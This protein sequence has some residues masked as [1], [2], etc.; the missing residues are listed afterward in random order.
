MDFDLWNIV[1]RDFQK[2]FR[3]MNEWNDLEKKL[4]SLNMKALNAS[5]CTL[6][7]MSLIVLLYEK[8]HMT[9]DT[10]SKSHMKVQVELKSLKLIFWCIVLNSFE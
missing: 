9:F 4:F 5:F 3:P 6:D 8:L 7:K 2:S 1:E 10:H